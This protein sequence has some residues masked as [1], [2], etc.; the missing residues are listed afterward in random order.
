MKRRSYS[1]RWAHLYG[2][3][4]CAWLLGCGAGDLG[5]VP[6]GAQDVA[7]F[8]QTVEAGGVPTSSAMNVPGFLAEHDLPLDSPAC[9]KT[10]CL[11]AAAG[12]ARAAD[13]GKSEVFLQ[14][15]LDTNLDAATFQRPPADLAVVI[16]RSGSMS[17][18]KIAA[19]RT[20]LHKLVDQLHDTD[21]L[22]LLE[23]DDQIDVLQTPQPATAAV[24]AAAHRQIDTITARGMTDIE[25]A[26]QRAYGLISG[27]RRPG[28]MQR[29]IF[30][31]DGLPTAGKTSPADI[32]AVIDRY[33]AQDVG[34]TFL[35][36]GIDF[37]QDLALHITRS[38]GGNYQ[39]LSDATRIATLF[40]RDFDLLITPLAYD[41]H[42]IVR[43]GAGYRIAQ[44][45]GLPAATEGTSTALDIPTLFLSRNRG[46]LLLRLAPTGAWGDGS[47]LS[48]TTLSYRARLAD[49][50][51]P[52]EEQK[53]DSG[54]TGT[55]VL[56]DQ[57]VWFSQRG[58]S[59]TV[60]LVNTALLVN[61]GL[62]EYAQG[63][64]ASAIT[65]VQR[66][67]DEL[68]THQRQDPSFPDEQADV[69]LLLM[70]EQNIRDNGQRYVP[71]ALEPGQTP[72]YQPRHSIFG[73]AAVPGSGAAASWLGLTAP[74]LL[75]L[76]VR[77]RSRIAP[78]PDARALRQ[79]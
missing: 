7:L 8:R 22:A 23:F 14:L 76:L 3:A 68:R 37:G 33:A 40:D 43:A 50:V 78:E 69:D 5:V 79:C 64:R 51:G 63:R 74:L 62:T 30:M 61:Q 29:V 17:G 15:G 28:A 57:T 46:A 52:V 67:E 45:Y 72:T 60:A 26:L 70:L 58:V 25:G 10:L 54:Y 73:C 11:T 13:T 36:L 42:L 19:A 9:T 48:S 31:T 55:E 59:R 18:A 16:D 6:G 32:K 12:V 35:G 56:G 47:L 34:L 2:T 4:L 38:R 71:P 49:G 66:A 77:L 44:V 65:Y 39:F 41:V 27:G 53:A 24:R 21:Q 1:L 75:L 20:G